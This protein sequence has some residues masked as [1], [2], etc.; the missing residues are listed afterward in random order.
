M[1]ENT[2]KYLAMSLLLVLIG[3][4]KGTRALDTNQAQIETSA[5][6]V[7]DSMVF[8]GETYFRSSDS[9]FEC[10]EDVLK[11]SFIV[12]HP[13]GAV[14]SVVHQG[15]FEA[16]GMFVDTSKYFN[17]DGVLIKEIIHHN[18]LPN[19]LV[20][21]HNVMQEQTITEFHK[22]GNVSAEKMIQNSYEGTEYPSGVWKTFDEKGT[23]ISVKNYGNP[24]EE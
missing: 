8:E 2:L 16:C 3:C 23:L 7:L 13:N 11:G 21:C 1:S 9:T 17:P 5:T 20:G 14:K 4:D 10:I 6:V 18:W 12:I 22:N 24:Y 19:G 15:D